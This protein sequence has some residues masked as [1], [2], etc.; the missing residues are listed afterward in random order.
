MAKTHRVSLKIDEDLN[1]VLNLISRKKKSEIISEALRYFF[2]QEEILDK[3][4]NN[5][6]KDFV[7]KLIEVNTIEK[8]VIN[9]KNNEIESKKINTEEINYKEN[10]NNSNE[11]NFHKSNET[12]SNSFEKNNE[13]KIEKTNKSHW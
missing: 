3:F 11:N 13:V 4:F 1:S 8:E 6:T 9:E 2:S 12:E 7:K 10:I 5:T